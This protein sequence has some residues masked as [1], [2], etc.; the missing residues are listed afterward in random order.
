MLVKVLPETD[1]SFAM[2]KRASR[3][4]DFNSGGW[5]VLTAI[6]NNGRRHVSTRD[7]GRHGIPSKSNLDA[8]GDT[9]YRCQAGK[10]MC[11]HRAVY[12]KVQRAIAAK[13]VTHRAPL[14]A[15]RHQPPK[16]A[17]RPQSWYPSIHHRHRRDHSLHNRSSGAL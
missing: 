8:K 6:M 12:R 1:W 11:S 7:L 3:W 15:F 17:I 9:R 4:R 13:W 10:D 14:L 5:S 16:A 2:W